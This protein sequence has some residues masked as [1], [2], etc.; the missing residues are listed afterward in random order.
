MPA[1]ASCPPPEGS[2]LLRYA[3]GGGFVDAYVTSIDG[4]VDLATFVEAFYTTPLFRLE[5][6]L[7]GAFARRP[8][9][10]AEARALGRGERDSFAA[11]SLEARAQDQLLM[12]DFT[13]RTRS[14]L[15]VEA[16]AR[17]TRLLF[18]S[19]VVPARNE[20]Q[21]EPRLGFPFAALL[22]CHRLYSRLLLAAAAR[23]LRSRATLAPP[24]A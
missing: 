18:G 23:R 21:G 8:S 1:V 5:R 16:G 9:T 3:T 20:A 6:T 4:R 22:G 17:S 11:W 12:R 19:A 7:L 14:W 10:D 15:M 2:L 24:P 13:G